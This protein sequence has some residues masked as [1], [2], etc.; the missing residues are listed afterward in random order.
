[1][2]TFEEQTE[3]IVKAL[4]SEL[5]GDNEETTFRS[6]ESDSPLT[7][8]SGTLETKE[9]FDPQ[10]IACRLRDLGDQF[11]KEI[12]KSALQMVLDWGTEKVVADFPK[13]VDAVYSNWTSQ[14]PE[15]ASEKALLSV[16]VALVKCT[17]NKA[18]QLCE[19][20][21]HAMIT[22]Y[23]NMKQQIQRLGGWEHI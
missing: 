10:L 9:T 14:S 3:C 22:L 23:S 17:V 12:K 7:L 19:R 8:Q 15:T 11:N 18:P 5:L 2:K 20:L 1:M 4:L 13:A 16:S 21:E 6:L